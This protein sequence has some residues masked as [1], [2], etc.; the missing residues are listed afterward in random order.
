[1]LSSFPVALAVGAAA[2][3]LS[4]LGI[5]GGSLLILWLTLALH[6]P[7]TEARTI[8][9]LFFI[10]AAGA[11]SFYRWKKGSLQIRNILPAIIAGCISAGIFAWLSYQLDVEKLRKLFGILL[12]GVG[13]RELIYRP[14][15][16]K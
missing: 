8:N 10:A 15:E 16:F 2:G 6:M 1:M 14:K 5:G 11:V 13:I 3:F 4:G 9:L 12:I 7:Q